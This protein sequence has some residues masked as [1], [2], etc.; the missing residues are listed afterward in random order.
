[1]K[2]KLAN[3]IIRGIILLILISMSTYLLTKEPKVD[4]NN[5]GVENT[6][7]VCSDADGCTKTC[8]LRKK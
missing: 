7:G 4:L 3:N 2:S 8:P 6:M 5:C 1:M